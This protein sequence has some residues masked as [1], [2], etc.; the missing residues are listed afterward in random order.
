M[1]VSRFAEAVQPRL[2]WAWQ[3]TWCCFKS[4]KAGCSWCIEPA[5]CATDRRLSRLHAALCVGATRLAAA[6]ACFSTGRR[7]GW[8]S[9][10][11]PAV[12]SVA[13]CRTATKASGP[14][15]ALAASC[16][17]SWAGSSRASSVRLQN[18]ERRG[19]AGQ[20]VR[21]ELKRYEQPT[22]AGRG[23]PRLR[24]SGCRTTTEE[25]QKHLDRNRRLH[26]AQK[27]A[28]LPSSVPNKPGPRH[29]KSLRRA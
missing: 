10:L 19:K 15:C 11:P 22:A 23:R 16:T 24:P 14:S 20:C 21:S 27:D 2:E 1:S 9:M 8:L 6:Q 29:M 17:S 5:G 13:P 4:C 25:S 28:R 12:R 26:H 18:W 7:L 3:D